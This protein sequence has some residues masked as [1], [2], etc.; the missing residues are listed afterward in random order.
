M[1]HAEFR[2]EHP[3]APGVLL[4]PTDCPGELAPGPV[5]LDRADGHEVRIFRCIDC[6]QTVV[7]DATSDVVRNDYPDPRTPVRS[8]RLAGFR[9]VPSRE[10]TDHDPPS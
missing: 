5:Y 6:D 4:D 10:I 8:G 1:T 7:W 2:R 9:H 3:S